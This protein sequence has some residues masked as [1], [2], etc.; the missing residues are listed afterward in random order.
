MDRGWP[1]TSFRLRIRK[2]KRSDVL[3]SYD[4][5]NTLDAEIV[6]AFGSGGAFCANAL[7]PFRRF[8]VLRAHRRRRTVADA[9]SAVLDVIRHKAGSSNCRCIEGKHGPTRYL[10]SQL[11]SGGALD[12][13]R[14]V[15]EHFRGVLADGRRRVALRGR[16]HAAGDGRGQAVRP[17][18][19]CPEAKAIFPSLHE[20]GCCAPSSLD[21]D[22]CVA[23][24]LRVEPAAEAPVL[25]AAVA[26]WFCSRL[27]SRG[28]PLLRCAGP[29]GWAVGACGAHG[30]LTPATLHRRPFSRASR[31]AGPDVVHA[32]R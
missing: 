27:C 25:T 18:W 17:H 15:K 23:A 4:L 11:T 16:R 8:R 7:G 29:R 20:P 1:S 13:P 21:K 9:K 2:A 6:L 24:A 26:A 5:W 3:L 30:S 14:K 28:E 19:R 22:R 32:R 31:V 10:A 12:A